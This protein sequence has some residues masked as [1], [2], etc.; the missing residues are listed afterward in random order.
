MFMTAY[1]VS[2]SSPFFFFNDTATTDIYTLSLHDALPIS[3]G[4]LAVQLGGPAL[5][6]VDPGGRPKGD[7]GVDERRASEPAAH[8][9]A[10]LVVGVQLEQGRRRAEP[11]PG[12]AQLELAGGT[13]WRVGIVT[14]PELAAPLEHAHRAA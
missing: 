12:G 13:P 6:V 10:H 5:V 8:P 2:L 11:P 7:A 14:R 9:H 4:A 1:P 3:L